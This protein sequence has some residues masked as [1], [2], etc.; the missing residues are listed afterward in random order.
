MAIAANYLNLLGWEW[1]RLRQRMGFWA[2]VGIMGLFV[3]GNLV[4]VALATRLAPLAFGLP[5]QA[6]PAAAFLILAALGPFFGVVLASFLLGNEFAW[7]TWR[8]LVARGKPRHWPILSKLLLGGAILAAVWVLAWCVG[9]VFG[10]IAGD[11]SGGVIT[12]FLFEIPDGWGQAATQFFSSLPVAITYLALGALLCVVGRSPTFGVGVGIAIVIA[13]S[14]AYPLANA[15]IQGVYGFEI[16]EYTRWTL[17]GVSR[18]LMGRDE[19]SAAW[20]LPA[21]LAYLALFCGL[22]ILVFMRRDVDSGN[23]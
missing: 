1:F 2:I 21:L 15:I 11:D 22:S 7:G 19:L 9:S 4:V 8:T 23:A 3:V 13:E 18:G 17:W 10:L 20:F 16:H 5:A 6:Y 14:V 12:D